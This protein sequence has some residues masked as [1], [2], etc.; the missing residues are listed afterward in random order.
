MVEEIL[1]NGAVIAHWGAE[2][3]PSVGTE[4]SVVVNVAGTGA[5]RCARQRIA[6]FAARHQAL[7]NA[8]CD[9]ATRCELLVLL[10]QF[11]G[12]REG[13][14][15]ND[16]GDRNLDPID[17]SSFVVGAVA[18]ADAAAQAW[19]ACDTLARHSLGLS[20]ACGPLIGRVA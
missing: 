6:A 14:L 16:G 11:P 8:G 4:A 18:R 13:I 1:A 12:S 9:R 10:Q 15:I 7:D 5:R 17:T 2:A 3:S 19:R 20:E